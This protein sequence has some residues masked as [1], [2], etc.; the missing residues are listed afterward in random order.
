M[1]ELD[2]VLKEQQTIRAANE[3]L[4]AQKKLFMQLADEQLRDANKDKR[5]QASIA[6]DVRGTRYAGY[7]ASACADIETANRKLTQHI[8]DAQSAINKK[9]RDNE[10]RLTRLQA[11][12]HQ[13]QIN[14][15]KAKKS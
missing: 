14:K 11:E 13:M 10:E 7:M 2:E 12:Y 4:L 8:A 5:L 1:R 3:Q 9:L 6:E 15:K